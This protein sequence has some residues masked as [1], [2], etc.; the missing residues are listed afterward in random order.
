MKIDVLDLVVDYLDNNFMSY[1]VNE[2]D[3]KWVLDRLKLNND[4]DINV[5]IN[6]LKNETV[7]KI[8]S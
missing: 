3:I 2:D 5:I 8:V 4:V 6:R 7:Y 1:Y